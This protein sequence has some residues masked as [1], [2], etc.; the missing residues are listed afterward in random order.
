M[1]YQAAYMR[2][3]RFEAEMQAAVIA[4]ML[5]GGMAG[6]PQAKRNVP[7]GLIVPPGEKVISAQAFLGIAAP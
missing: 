2:R 4:E 5:A 7:E 1:A 3:I 6:Q